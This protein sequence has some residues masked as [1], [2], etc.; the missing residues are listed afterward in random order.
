[1][2]NVGVAPIY[3]TKGP[4]VRPVW[5][6]L[7]IVDMDKLRSEKL[8]NTDEVM[9]FSTLA[10]LISN[11]AKK[12]G[13][14]P[15]FG[16]KK[17]G[18][19]EWMTYSEFDVI[20]R[21]FRTLLKQKGFGHGDRIAVIA[22]NSVEFAAAAFGAYG[23]GGILVPMYEVQKIQD[24]EFIFGD[25]K[26]SIAVVA[27]DSIREKVEGLECESLKDI[28]VIKPEKGGESASMMSQINA[29]QELTE[30]GDVSADDVCD[31]IYTSGT[32][33]RPRGVV[34]THRSVCENTRRTGERFAISCEDRTMAFLPWAHAFGKTVELH[35]FPAV[36][37]AVGL[38][39]SSRTIAQNLKEVN[40]TILISVPKI[41]NK[42]YDTIHL[43]VEG[44]KLSSMMFKQA[45]GL[46]A[47]A[48]AGKLSL[49]GKAQNAVLDRPETYD[50]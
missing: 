39:E 29:V 3:G 2:L 16:V 46:A 4:D 9:V 41:F 26:P 21:K 43:K 13:D 35:I 44:K 42:I 7:R 10:E 19:Y 36:G 12:Y 25:S 33:G 48:N 11:S 17:N 34:L 1:M 22:N 6:C 27:N 37:A 28:F 30:I 31:I 18:V 50:S 40:P 24:W 8:T 23:L 47:R 38:V 14:R 45:E 15:Y 49:F 32:T 20:V 5:Y